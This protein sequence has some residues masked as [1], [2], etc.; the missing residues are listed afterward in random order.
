M[1]KYIILNNYIENY[2]QIKYLEENSY[3]LLNNGIDNNITLTIF[4]TNENMKYYIKIKKKYNGIFK[5]CHVKNI[6]RAYNYTLELY[7]NYILELLCNI[8][9]NNI[10]LIKGSILYNDYVL[11][12][13]NLTTFI[14]LEEVFI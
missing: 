11:L 10:C 8:Y 4:L 14:N 6:N 2:D 9:E 5:K 12:Y 1:D 7:N 13:K 3:I